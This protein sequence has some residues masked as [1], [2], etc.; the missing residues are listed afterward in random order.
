MVE[1][2]VPILA[3]CSNNGLIVFDCQTNAQLLNIQPHNGNV[4]SLSWSHNGMPRVP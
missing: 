3:T 4:N 2:N 1:T